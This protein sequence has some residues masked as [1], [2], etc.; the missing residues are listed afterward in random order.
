MY[1]AKPS[2]KIDGNM[3]LLWQ[4]SS[5]EIHKNQLNITIFSQGNSRNRQLS[6]ECKKWNRLNTPGEMDR[7]A[8]D[9]N[10]ESANRKIVQW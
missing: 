6:Q 7:Q 9:K 10:E 8:K 1:S 2:F 4:G 3:L 5:Q